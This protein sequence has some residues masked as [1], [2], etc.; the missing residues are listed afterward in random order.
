M[1]NYLKSC[2]LCGKSIKYPNKKEF[3]KKLNSE[4]KC[5]GCRKME[6]LTFE[7]AR[8]IVKKLEL[9]DRKSWTSWIKSEEGKKYKIPSNPDKFYK[10]CGWISYSDWLGNY[11]YMNIR[12]INYMDY[13]SCKK[14][15]ISNF[16]S[17]INKSK[18][19]IKKILEDK[20]GL[21]E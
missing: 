6:F 8:K 17:I 20:L 2:S 18:W 7:S 11:N 13:V 21:Y 19:K 3:T 15:M 10:D 9:K 5:K 1:K 16:P 4:V 14:Y 12:N